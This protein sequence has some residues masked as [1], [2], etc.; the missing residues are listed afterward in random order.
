M[1]DDINKKVTVHATCICFEGKGILLLGESGSGKSDLALRL[2]DKGCKLVADDQVIL[3]KENNAIIANSPLNIKGLL[4]V[5][6]VGIVTMPIEQNIAINL[7]VVLQKDRNIERLPEPK[8]YE[9]LGIN[10]SQI[11]I[12]PFDISAAIKVITKLS[13]DVILV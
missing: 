5:R 11:D 9:I 12:Y 7:A 8:Y 1:N 3:H 6:G 13:V 10:I 2:I 4:E